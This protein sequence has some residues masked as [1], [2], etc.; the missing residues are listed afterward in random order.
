M[1]S[2]GTWSHSGDFLSECENGIGRDILPFDSSTSDV[3]RIV[4]G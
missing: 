3:S 1:A 2:V 4:N